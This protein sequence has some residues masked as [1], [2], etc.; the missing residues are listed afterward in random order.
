ML[1]QGVE[2]GQNRIEVDLEKVLTEG[3][4]S[5]MPPLKS[6]D[7]IFIPK[8]QEAGIWKQIVSVARDVSTIGLAILIILGRRSY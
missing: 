3:Q 1:I 4:F 2:G 7:T 8:K 6:G 5:L